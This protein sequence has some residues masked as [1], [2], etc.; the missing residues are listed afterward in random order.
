MRA[1]IT[2]EWRHF[3]DI[4]R[5]VQGSIF[6]KAEE[7]KFTHWDSMVGIES[8]QKTGKSWDINDKNMVL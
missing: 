6:Q 1:E 8:S 7:F 4:H 3:L 2:E 5:T